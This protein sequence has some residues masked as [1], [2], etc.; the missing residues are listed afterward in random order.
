[1]GV[2]FHP[3]EFDR[4]THMADTEVVAQI[5]PQ[6]QFSG[7][8]GQS[9]KNKDQSVGSEWKTMYAVKDREEHDRNNDFQ[10]FTRR[11]FEFRPPRRGFVQRGPRMKHFRSVLF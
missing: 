6:Q 4:H 10:A 9:W 2:T 8:G 5:P 3:V 11:Q 1:V 7:H